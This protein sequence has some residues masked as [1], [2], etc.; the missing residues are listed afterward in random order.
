MKIVTALISIIMMLMSK[1]MI[2]QTSSLIWE[3]CYGSIY[4]EKAHDIAA[5][6]DGGYIVAGSLF[7]RSGDISQSYGVLDYWIVKISSTGD[8][9]WE[10]SLG[11]T[12][13]DVAYSIKQTYDGGYIVA[14]TSA[15]NNFFVTGN[16]GAKDFWIVKLSE[17]GEVEWQRTF[18]G[19]GDDIPS[20]VE[21]TSDNGYVIVGLTYAQG[22]HV[23][24]HFGL[25]DGWIIK[26]SWEGELQ[27]QKSFGGSQHD[28][29][30]GVRQ[31]NDGGYIVGGQSASDDGHLASMNLGSTDLW[32]L[33]LGQQGELMWQKMLG[34]S[35]GELGSKVLIAENQDYFIAGS[36]QSNDGDVSNHYGAGDFWLV[37]LDQSGTIIWDKTFG[38]YASEILDGARNSND[39]GV[40]LCGFTRSST[41]DVTQFNGGLMDAWIMKTNSDGSLDWQISVGGS[42]SDRAHAAVVS[43]DGGVI[44]A[45]FTESD[46]G[47]ISNNLGVGD[48]WVVKV[49][50]PNG[51]G[52]EN[53]ADSQVH[54]FPNPANDRL[55]ID[56]L[57]PNSSVIIR[58]S[59]GK[60]VHTAHVNDTIHIMS[61]SSFA[62]GIYLIE[63]AGNKFT[64]KLIVA[65]E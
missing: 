7:H 65:K 24:E 41:L 25:Y 53:E 42:D 18:G 11:G 14:G 17:V 56:N 20:E 62:N 15:S 54:L 55:I 60:I 39:G 13:Y 22:G 52:L 16:H 38:G 64:Q 58:N 1:P 27:W 12:Q 59:L 34:G 46:D 44:A 57:V 9:Q 36:T 32:V 51:L 26:L 33:K 31:T 21:Q 47:D 6:S 50:G 19:P 3:R 8:I 10:K 37:R 49:A 2:C 43:H 63:I 30:N 28:I 48:L 45:G 35:E 5:T 40:I 23:T 29:F 61:T 4:Y